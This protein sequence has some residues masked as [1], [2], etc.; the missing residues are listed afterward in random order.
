MLLHLLICAM[1]TVCVTVSFHIL[2][3]A[4]TDIEYDEPR[5]MSAL[6]RGAGKDFFDVPVN[7][8]GIYQKGT[9][10]IK[11]P[12]VRISYESYEGRSI[13]KLQSGI[14]LLIFKI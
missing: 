11:I 14:I 6:C 9:H 3:D 7:G 1:L 4:R 8:S 12:R 10:F 13:N 2:L 5:G